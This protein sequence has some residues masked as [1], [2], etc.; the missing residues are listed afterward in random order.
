MTG[1]AQLPVR[2][3]WLAASRLLGRPCRVDEPYPHVCRIGGRRA[4]D[5][6]AC[7]EQQRK[8]AES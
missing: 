3:I 2:G 1:P 7:A 6:G 4:R 5:C 8:A